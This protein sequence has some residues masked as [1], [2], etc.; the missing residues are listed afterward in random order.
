MTG[1]FRW[2]KKG[3]I[4]APD[5]RFEWMQSHAQNPSVLVLEDRLRVYF[6]CRPPRDKDGNFAAVTTFVDLKKDDPGSVTYVHPRPI[7]PL[8]G[9]GTFDQFG[10]MPGCALAVG[11]EVWLYYVGW[12]RCHGAPYTHA[13]GLA[14]SDDGGSNFRRL[15]S[16]PLFG[17]SPKEPFLQNSPTVFKHGGVFH[18][19]YSSGIRWVEQDG[20]LESIY[21][22]MHATSRDGINWEREGVPCVPV[23]VEDEVQTNPT[24]TQVGGRFYMWFC[25][26]WGLDFRNPERG[27][28]IG[29]AW[30]D[31]L[32]NWQR[33]DGLG[34][35]E[36]SAEGWD[37]EMVC[38]PCVVQVGGQI[39]MFYSGN[40][41]G[42]DGFGYAVGSEGDER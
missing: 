40:Y 14:V 29:L 23:R 15:G 10:V 41:F 42:R 2:E 37:S 39:Y 7:L 33:D 38:Y 32:I 22:L 20:R 17:R 5:G 26:R 24:V 25:Y 28:R 18:M 11:S 6:T 34:V 1:K 30:S 35:V 4:F 9:V 3:L 8:G 27:Y 21:V 13:I 19:W 16:G 12:M 36:P 31:D